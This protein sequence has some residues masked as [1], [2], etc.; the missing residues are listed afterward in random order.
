MSLL[1]K[2]NTDI[3]LFPEEVVEDRDGNTRTQASS[4]GIPMSVWIQ[5]QGQSGTAARRSEQDGEGYETEKTYRMRLRRID[6]D[7]EIGAQAK[8]ELNG[9]IWTVFGD[10]W[11]YKGSSRT[12]HRVI[13]LR[14]S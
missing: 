5:P 11:V 6:Q 4:V 14:R 13:L 1:D 7:I 3:I 8:V 10:E 2:G 12:K 9:Q